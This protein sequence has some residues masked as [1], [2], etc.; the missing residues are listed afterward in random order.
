M[1]KRGTMK[2]HLGF[3][4]DLIG[5]AQPKGELV[6]EIDF[7]AADGRIEADVKEI[8]FCSN[9]LL[10]ALGKMF[11]KTILADEIA[12]VINETIV[13][14][15]SHDPRIRKIEILNGPAPTEE[16]PLEVECSA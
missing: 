10:D 15:P 3:E 4:L 16:L 1:N 12:K 8:S 7:Y 14:L 9:S 6:M 11:G 13:E 5:L 2:L